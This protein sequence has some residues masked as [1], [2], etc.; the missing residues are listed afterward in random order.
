MVLRVL[1]SVILTGLLSIQFLSAQG[2]YNPSWQYR[3]P[4]TVSNPG[5][6]VL[7]D[8]QV[9]VTLTGGTGGNFDFTKARSDGSD[10]LFTGSDGTTLISFWIESW[11][12]PTS[13]T[14]WVKVPSVAA[15]PSTTVVY[16]YYNNPIATSTAN[17]NTTFEFFDDFETPSTI[18]GGYYTLSNPGTTILVQDQAWENSAPHT[19]D[20][21]D[22]GS[23]QDG[24]R[25]WGYYG[26]QAYPQGDGVGLAR[27]NDLA[28]WTKYVSN[29]VIN[30]DNAR[31]PSVLLVGSTLHIFYTDYTER[32]S[33]IV[34][35]T[36]SNGITISP[37]IK[38]L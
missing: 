20:V 8:F 18:N 9:K 23:A 30:V 29:P 22:W 34:R 2:W 13:A 10:I 12:P 27:S 36:S 31:W 7:S 6:T 17:G 5:G 11:N 35:E 15:Y 21:V 19:L 28:T 3:S 16:L 32:N 33:T 4:V 25:Y 14:I 24:Y 38:P 37:L 26:V 1:T